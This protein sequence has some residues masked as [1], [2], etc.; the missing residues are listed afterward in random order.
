[1]ND[2]IHSHQQGAVLT[3]SINRPDKLNA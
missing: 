1:M 3:L 2:L